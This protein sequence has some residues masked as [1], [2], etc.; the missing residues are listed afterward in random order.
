MNKQANFSDLLEQSFESQGSFAGRVI[1]GTVVRV[2]GDVVVIDV[3][4]KSEGRVPLKEFETV[5]LSEIKAGD[6]VDVFVEQLE[7]KNGEIVLSVE[8]ARKEAAWIEFEKAFSDGTVVEGVIFGRIKGGFSV[9]LC[10]TMA[11]LPGSQVDV[12]PVNDI[13]P[14]M[15]IKQPFKIIKIDKA[16]NNIV[17]SRRVVLE[18]S[19]AGAREEVLS[20]LAEGQIIKGVVKNITDYGAFVDLGGIDGLLHATDMSWKRIGHP[21]EVVSVGQEIDVIVLKFS[22]E[23]QRIS[24]G[25][26]QLLS[27][28]W[29]GVET[30]YTVGEKYK[31]IVTNVADYGAFVELEP[32]IEGLI[33]ITEMSWL[34][35]GAN[36]HRV[37]S[38]GQEVEIVVL[39]V[40]SKT[41]RMSLGLKQ[42][43]ENPWEQFAKANPVGSVIEGTVRNATEFGLFVGVTDMLDG[44]VHMSDLSWKQKGDDAIR[45]FER[46]QK[47]MVKILD[48]DFTN[49]RISLGI[50]QAQEEDVLLGIRRGDI[51]TCTIK[52]V[53]D[54]GIEVV[55]KDNLV[56][57][58]RRAD[59]SSDRQRQRPELYA[60]GERVDAKVIDV[61]PTYQKIIVSIRA[62]E[63]DEE[64]RV[65]A[66]YGSTDSGASLGSILGE[67][68]QKKNDEG[69]GVGS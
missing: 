64:R 62:K 33:Y 24:L 35:K 7:D 3:G 67:A 1:K 51:V 15:G 12:R 34:R 58:I 46:G 38:P 40:D 63:L 11:F 37:V 21:S 10:G 61:K 13:T 23:T 25:I 60:V 17:V 14:L 59:L 43:Q 49:E 65:L 55:V 54:R 2:H 56:T 31:G 8:K 22:P 6:V 68:I 9:E 4:L 44:M 45:T 47:V 20:N 28:P 26:K 66:E 19:M 69:K 39:A 30:R 36:A 5:G 27:N 52:E 42:C 41:R 50:K 57:F 16:R 53:N 32:G 48:I 29:D 18:D